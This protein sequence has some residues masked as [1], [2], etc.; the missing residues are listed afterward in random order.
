[1]SKLIRKTAKR[2]DLNKGNQLLTNVK[3]R[4]ICEDFEA[5]CYSISFKEM[6]RQEQEQADK[7][8]GQK[9]AHKNEGDD[10]SDVEHDKSINSK[11]ELIKSEGNEN[12]DHGDED[13]SK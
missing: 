5:H 13:H 8:Q 11:E 3:C 2:L 10:V 1:M 7:D 4:K 6:Q 9:L 12:E